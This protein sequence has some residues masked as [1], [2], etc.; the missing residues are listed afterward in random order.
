MTKLFYRWLPIT[1]L[2]VWSAVFLLFYATQR[3]D[4]YLAPEFRP[5]VLIAGALLLLMAIITAW[6]GNAELCCADASCS[7]AL[8]RTKRGRTVMFATLI[9]PLIAAATFSKDQYSLSTVLNRGVM[10]DLAPRSSSL[11]ASSAQ[12]QSVATTQTYEPPLPSNQPASAQKPA[13]Q[14]P[15]T[16]FAPR[17]KDGNLEME[18]TDLLYAQ[19]DATLR[20]AMDGKVI[21]M[22]GQIMP[23]TT[24]DPHHNRVQLM[25]MYMWCCAADARPV[26]AL[27]QTTQP[28][29]I[30]DM[31]WV[32]VIGKVTFPVEN[33]HHIAVLDATSVQK[34]N[35]PKDVMVY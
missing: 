29:K 13:A 4:K 8:S 27:V 7:H 31:A 12:T 30:P 25:R 14:S 16:D 24:D 1:T 28:P 10:T 22:V 26:A 6:T 5:L 3:I 34:T 32:R 33:G 2:F 35:P 23:A 20:P 9:L 11:T 15:P 18:V 17:A 19:A 21:E